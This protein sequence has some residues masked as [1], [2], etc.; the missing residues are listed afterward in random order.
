[1]TRITRRRRATAREEASAR[2]GVAIIVGII[3][4]R[5]RTIDVVVPS[6][7]DRARAGRGRSLRWWRRRRRLVVPEERHLCSRKVSKS[8]SYT[9]VIA[10]HSDC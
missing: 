3:G 7:E 5:G 1:M 6:G 4:G 9:I 2:A 10:T 8:S